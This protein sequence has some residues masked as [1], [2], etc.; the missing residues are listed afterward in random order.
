LV[1]DSFQEARAVDPE[2]VQIVLK[3]PNAT[4]LYSLAILTFDFA[5]PASVKR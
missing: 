4:L 3:K 1:A 5:S 2:T